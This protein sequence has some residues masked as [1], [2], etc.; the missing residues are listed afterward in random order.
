MKM[1]IR[2]EGD[3]DAMGA[4]Y[5]IRGSAFF[6]QQSIINLFRSLVNFSHGNI[7][8]ALKCLGECAK[9]MEEETK[10]GDKDV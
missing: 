2:I 10:G 8:P 9:I 6:L 5:E 4:S 3:D 1:Y 7:M